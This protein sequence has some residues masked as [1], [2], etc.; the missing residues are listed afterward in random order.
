MQMAKGNLVTTYVLKIIGYVENSEKLVFSLSQKLAIDLVLQLL[1]HNYGQ[2]V[3]NYNINENDKLLLE[4]LSM[5]KMC[6]SFIWPKLQYKKYVGFES[7]NL[8]CLVYML[9][10]GTSRSK[11]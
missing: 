6:F 2:F 11:M 5:L 9:L 8:N 10:M 3:I 1:L 4:L 7:F